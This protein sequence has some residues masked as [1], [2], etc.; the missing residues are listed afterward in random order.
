EAELTRQRAAGAPLCAGV[1][2]HGFERATDKMQAAGD[3]DAARYLLQAHVNAHR[4]AKPP[5]LELAHLQLAGCQRNVEARLAERDAFGQRQAFAGEVNVALEG[6][7]YAGLE[8]L[9]RPGARAAG[10]GG[11]CRPCYGQPLIQQRGE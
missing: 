11:L 1:G 6:V 10:N 3:V 8:R 7:E 4:A 2:G 9:V 5:S